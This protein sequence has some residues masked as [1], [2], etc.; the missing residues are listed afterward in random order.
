MR[1]QY[2]KSRTNQTF[3]IN[4]TYFKYHRQSPLP[5]QILLASKQGFA[6]PELLYENKSLQHCHSYDMSHIAMFFSP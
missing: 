2:L 1:K 5:Q 4:S 3:T 6:R